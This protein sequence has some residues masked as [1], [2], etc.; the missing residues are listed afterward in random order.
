MIWHKTERCAQVVHKTEHSR[1]GRYGRDGR[2]GGD[3]VQL[4]SLDYIEFV[5]NGLTPQVTSVYLHEFAMAR[6]VP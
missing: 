4:S 6:Y 5:A 1:A 2:D 3:V